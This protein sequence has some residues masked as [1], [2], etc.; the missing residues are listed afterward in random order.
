MIGLLLMHSVLIGVV[1]AQSRPL[2]DNGI[3]PA[4]IG[5][6]DWIYKLYNATNQLDGVALNVTDVASL[7]AFEKSH[8]MD[9]VVVKAGTGSTNY[10]PE[11]TPQF[12][13][14]LV[15]KAHAA[16]LKIFGYTRS[17]GR[18]IP[19]EVALVSAVYE[20]GADGFVVD[21]EAEWQSNRSWIGTNGP[22]LANKMLSAI[23]ARYP[24]KFLAYSTFPI[25]HYHLSIP[26]KEFG[27]YCDTVM[28][29][30]YWEK[31][32]S[33]GVYT[34]AQGID[35]TDQEWKRWQDSLKGEDRKAIKPIAP[36]GYAL[37]PCPGWPGVRGAQVSEFA[38]YLLA[39]TNAPTAGGYKGISFYA[40][41]GGDDCVRTEDIWQ[42]L[43]EAN[44]HFARLVEK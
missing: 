43:T 24:K 19:G 10:P 9:F 26:Y 21:V 18:D 28:P 17:Y 37:A 16:G 2:L 5:R 34:P 4:N 27:T 30:I 36:V 20:M 13:A 29:Q 25:I 39:D 15:Q 44:A 8:G 38:R 33:I 42:G 3:D 14:D 1:Q 12:T 23:R 11:S 40:T 6:G 32:R 35:R 7:M 41:G 31:W 22:V